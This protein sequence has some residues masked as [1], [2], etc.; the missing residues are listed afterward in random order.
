M[1]KILFLLLIANAGFGQTVATYSDIGTLKNSNLLM[2]NT[3]YIIQDIGKIQLVAKGVNS[4][5]EKPYMRTIFGMDFDEETFDFDTRVLQVID[6]VS[7][8]CRCTNAGWSIIND[9]GHKPYKIALVSSNLMVHYTKA[10]DKVIGFST[11]LDETY[12]GSNLHITAGAS[13][14]LTKAT[15]LFYKTDGNNVPLQKQPATI[16]DL[17]IY[18]SN[19]FING[20][21]AK[22]L[23]L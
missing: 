2:P 23:Q 9:V 12:S 1:K 20:R 21:M 3:V 22:Y 11:S 13:A 19:I 10:Y 15:I 8:V 4:F 16:Q 5:Y 17:S 6:N 7:C 14:G 18:G